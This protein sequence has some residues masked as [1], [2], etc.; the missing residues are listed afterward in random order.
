[1]YLGYVLSEI[2]ILV[3]IEI[4]VNKVIIASIIE[5]VTKDVCVFKMWVVLG[6]Q[7]W[8][9]SHIELLRS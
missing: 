6:S 4:T 8:V 5:V 2:V 7:C 3:I 9:V 1:M